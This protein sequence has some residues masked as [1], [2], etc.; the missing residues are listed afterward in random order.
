ME[1]FGINRF[2]LI[3]L[4]TWQICLIFV[5][6]LIFPV[7]LN[8]VPKWR[9]HSMESFGKNCFVYQ[10]CNGTIEF[11][12]V[13]FHSMALEFDWICGSKSYLTALFSQVQFAGV[14]IGTLGNGSL[15]DLFGRKWISLLNM[16]V[17]LTMMI[18][19]GLCILKLNQKYCITIL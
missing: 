7:F 18:L 19:S 8:Y 14:L 4:S 5:T 13:D 1:T 6:Q 10:S 2:H 11:E 15:S 16:G 9:C 12:Q 3:V 17:A